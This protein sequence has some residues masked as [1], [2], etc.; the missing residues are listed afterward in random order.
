M[1]CIGLFGLRRL[2]LHSRKRAGKEALLSWSSGALL[3]VGHTHTETRYTRLARDLT[4][5]LIYTN[6]WAHIVRKCD[7]YFFI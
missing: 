1:S 3:A 7:R 6:V 4:S 2:H 5:L